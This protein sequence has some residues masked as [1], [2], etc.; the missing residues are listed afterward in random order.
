MLEFGTLSALTGDLRYVRAAHR[1]VR[2]VFRHR[3]KQ[4]GL[5]SWL[6]IDMA[7]LLLNWSMFYHIGD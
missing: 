1:A 6:A 5:V 4:T 3:S 7:N 2:Q